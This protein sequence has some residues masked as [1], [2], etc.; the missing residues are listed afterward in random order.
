MT[1]FPLVVLKNKL[2]TSPS[3]SFQDLR[4]KIITEINLLRERNDIIRAAVRQM[5]TRA[6]TCFVQNGGYI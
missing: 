3:G 1:F 6:A 4:S 2:S 5:Q